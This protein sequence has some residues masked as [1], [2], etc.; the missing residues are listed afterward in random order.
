MR[1]TNI[2]ELE[3][4]MYKNDHSIDDAMEEHFDFLISRI[5]TKAMHEVFDRDRITIIAVVRE[6]VMSQICVYER[7]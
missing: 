4:T 5:T 2:I 1:K 3:A 6:I 7:D